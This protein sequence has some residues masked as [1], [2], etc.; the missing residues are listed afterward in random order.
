M[1]FIGDIGGVFD[2]FM[3][4]IGLLIY[5]IPEH[6]FT[7]YAIKTLFLASSSN[8]ELFQ[9]PK[10]NKNN[11]STPKIYRNRKRPAST[12]KDIQQTK[13]HRQIILSCY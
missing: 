13:K 5:K 10:I 8:E 7:L 2:V 12:K 3:Y 4:F 9:K 11:S 1:D 6:S